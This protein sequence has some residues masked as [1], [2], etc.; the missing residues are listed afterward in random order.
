[1]ASISS[2]VAR[3]MRRAA[4]DHLGD[5]VVLDFGGFPTNPDGDGR[6]MRVLFS[7]L[8]GPTSPEIEQSINR[9]L[10]GVAARPLVVLTW[11][12]DRNLQIDL[13]VYGQEPPAASSLV[14]G[15]LF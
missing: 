2:V 3:R 13:K 14:Q 12:S 4:L 5:Q 9:M 7:D 11:L 8:V 15:G 1:M 10:R 6:P